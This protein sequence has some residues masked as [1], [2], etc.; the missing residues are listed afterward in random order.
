MPTGSSPLLAA[1]ARAHPIPEQVAT[2][3]QEI[4]DARRNLERE[5]AELNAAKEPVACT[6]ACDV[7]RQIETDKAGF[8]LFDRASQCVATAVLLTQQLAEPATPE[9][10]QV[11]Q[12][13]KTLLE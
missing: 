11:H 4:E 7:R 13:L 9:Q 12:G 1:G 6:K 5:E 8:P 2:R 10:R 3:R